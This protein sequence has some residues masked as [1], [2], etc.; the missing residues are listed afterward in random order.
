MDFPRWS[1]VQAHQH[2]S[3]AITQ[4]LEQIGIMPACYRWYL[5]FCGYQCI[6]D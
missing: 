5:Y 2:S 1:I 6:V 4:H 3:G